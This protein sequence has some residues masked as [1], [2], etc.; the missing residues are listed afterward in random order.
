MQ[1]LSQVRSFV[2][3]GLWAVSLC[4]CPLSTIDWWR[5]PLSLPASVARTVKVASLPAAIG[6]LAQNTQASRRIITVSTANRLAA[7][8]LLEKENLQKYV[9]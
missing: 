9:A 5:N 2:A 6:S 4:F 7:S 3:R 8:L 1:E